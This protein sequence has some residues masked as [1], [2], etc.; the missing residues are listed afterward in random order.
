MAQLTDVRVL[1]VDDQL[2]F[3]E[4]ARMVVE[5]TD[6]FEVAGEA[7]NGEEA[8]E[9]ART[10]MP[11]LVLMD[12][13]MPG[14]DGLEATRRIRALDNPPPVAVMSTHES[15]DYRDTALIAGAYAFLP[16]SEFGMDALEDLWRQAG[17]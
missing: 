4:A 1:I 15:G 10:L 13:Q 14:I 12:V 8:V 17:S 5:M 16:K 2:P 7:G 11:D 9:L 3:R 6:G